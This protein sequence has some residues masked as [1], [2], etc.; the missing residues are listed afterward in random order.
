MVKDQ[1]L[2][3]T[4]RF[5][6]QRREIEVTVPQG[7]KSN[8][9][10]DQLSLEAEIKRSISRLILWTPQTEV[11]IAEVHLW[12][13]VQPRE[14]RRDWILLDSHSVTIVEIGDLKMAQHKMR[15]VYR[16]LP[17]ISRKYSR[18][19]PI[20]SDS[21]ALVTLCPLGKLCTTCH[22]FALTTFPFSKWHVEKDMRPSL[23]VSFLLLKI[24]GIQILLTVSDIWICLNCDFWRL[25]R[26]FVFL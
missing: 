18:G 22:D 14:T 13:R 20:A 6:I 2:T 12:E 4:H 9:I 10:I 23:L 19:V 16:H 5:A 8:R 3:K 17:T 26:H 25:T 7:S 21:S 1:S 24:F 15:W 11:L